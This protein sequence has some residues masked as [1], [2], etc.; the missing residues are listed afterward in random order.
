[1]HFFN[2]Y[3][4]YGAESSLV[5]LESFSGG[6]KPNVYIPAYKFYNTVCILYTIRSVSYT[7]TEYYVVLLRT[8]TFTVYTVRTHTSRFASPILCPLSRLHCHYVRT[9]IYP[10][11][12]TKGILYLSYRGRQ[13]LPR[14]FSP[15]STRLISRAEKPEQTT[16]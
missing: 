16:K 7:T 9:G 3:L 13:F 10:S 2:T 11:K 6:F 5:T 8:I 12:F 14:K 4:S 15:C 1:M